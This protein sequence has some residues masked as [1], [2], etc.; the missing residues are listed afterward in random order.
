MDNNNETRQCPRDCKQCSLAQQAY[1]SAQIALS[2]MDMV[3]ALSDKFEAFEPKVNSIL[4]QLTI[5]TP[6]AQVRGSGAENRL[7]G[8]KP[9]DKNNELQ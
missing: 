4:E 5:V 6:I 9:K 2:T 3:K 7:P 8:N 1:C